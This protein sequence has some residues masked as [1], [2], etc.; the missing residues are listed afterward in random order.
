MNQVVRNRKKENPMD[1][2]RGDSTFESTIELGFDRN[3]F[4][5]LPWLV[6]PIFVFVLLYLI[7]YV[8]LLWLQPYEGMDMKSQLTADYSAW[9]PLAFQP[10][11]PAILEEIKKE[12]GLP[13]QMVVDGESWSTP[14]GIVT[15]PPLTVS[16]ANSTLLPTL[17]NPPTSSASFEPPY[18]ATSIPTSIITV[19]TATVTPQPNQVAT[20]TTTRKPIKTPRTPKPHKT[21]KTK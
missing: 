7:S 20:L 14:V 6:A 21:P 15:L 17:D 5:L 16:G 13:E 12:R 19:P 18:T 8:A 1:A 3:R 4:K 9:A 10:V 2:N 11:D